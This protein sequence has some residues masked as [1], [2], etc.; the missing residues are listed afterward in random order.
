MGACQSKDQQAGRSLLREYR[1]QRTVWR[2]GYT[3]LG[4]L[5]R[6]ELDT[7]PTRGSVTIMS[8]KTVVGP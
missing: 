4:M 5:S 6:G 7:V 8:P 3:I 1:R 2:S